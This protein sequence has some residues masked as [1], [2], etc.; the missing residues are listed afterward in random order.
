MYAIIQTGGKQYKVE[1]G[2]VLRVEKLEK[3]VGEKASTDNENVTISREEY[4]GFQNAL[5]IINDRSL[6]LI[7][8]DKADE[9]GYAIRYAD[10]KIYDRSYPDKKAF[11]I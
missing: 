8:R 7:E 3:Q 9:H 5:R 6:Q 2:D 4:N 11:F 10:Q 1:K